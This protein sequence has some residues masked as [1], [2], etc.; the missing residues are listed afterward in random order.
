MLPAAGDFLA[1][2][3]NSLA[4]DRSVIL[5]NNGEQWTWAGM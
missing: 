3:L 2:G 1:G 5:L 4:V